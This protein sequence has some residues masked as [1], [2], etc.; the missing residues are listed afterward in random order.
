MVEVSREIT[1][2]Q[3][4]EYKDRPRELGNELISP[5]IFIGY[6]VYGI[7]LVEENEKYFLRYNRGSSCD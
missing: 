6:G 3:Y 2:E 5:D 7:R 4:N 1:K